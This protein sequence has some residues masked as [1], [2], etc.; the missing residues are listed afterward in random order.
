MDTCPTTSAGCRPRR[1]TP[2]V[3][4][5]SRPLCFPWR[6]VGVGTQIGP[7]GRSRASRARTGVPLR[8]VCSQTGP[9]P[10]R[11]RTH[12]PHPGVAAADPNLLN[13]SSTKP[14]P[15]H[16]QHEVS[17]ESGNFRKVVVR[18]VCQF[19][20]TITQSEGGFKLWLHCSAKCKL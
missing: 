9:N 15:N 17:L 2:L 4:N 13:H 1:A 6:P 11:T 18:L 12:E 16:C 19:V 3:P 5:I 7:C 14:E 8:C 20:K 10:P